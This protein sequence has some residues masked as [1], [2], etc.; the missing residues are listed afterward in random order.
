MPNLRSSGESMSRFE[1]RSRLAS[2]KINSHPEVKKPSPARPQE[3]AD[4]NT[5]NAEFVAAYNELI[6]ANGVALEEY[7]L[8]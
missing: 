3:P 1:S 4:W 7:R 6:D 2:K 5:E 8:F